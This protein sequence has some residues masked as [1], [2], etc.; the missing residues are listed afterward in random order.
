MTGEADARAKDSRAIGTLAVVS[1]ALAV[2]VLLEAGAVRLVVAPRFAA[3][4]EDFDATLPLLTRLFVGWSGYAMGCGLAAAAAALA[5]VGWARRKNEYAV[6]GVVT[7]ALLTLLLP[8]L[9]II[10]LYLPIFTLSGAVAP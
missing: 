3:M 4:L 5:C 6:A 1:V 10:S 8:A 2:V 7:V 9:A